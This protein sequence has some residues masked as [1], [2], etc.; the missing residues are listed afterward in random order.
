MSLCQEKDAQLTHETMTKQYCNITDLTSKIPKARLGCIL[1]H[2][3]VKAP[4]ICFVELTTHM[5]LYV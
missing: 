3:T 1:P 2:K 4:L 5:S